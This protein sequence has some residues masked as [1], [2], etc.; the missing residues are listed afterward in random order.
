MEKYQDL[1]RI[2]MFSSLKPL[3]SVKMVS[4]NESPNEKALFLLD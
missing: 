3:K 2:N 1:S 4:N